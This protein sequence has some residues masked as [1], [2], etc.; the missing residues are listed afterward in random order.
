MM[1]TLTISKPRAAVAEQTRLRT[2]AL[3]L[4][5]VLRHTTNQEGGCR[6]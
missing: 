6:R 3:Q 1:T 5:F 4:E 2:L